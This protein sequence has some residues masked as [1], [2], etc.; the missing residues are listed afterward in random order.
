[1]EG[2][3]HFNSW[4][5][6]RE[7]VQRPSVEQRHKRVRPTSHKPGTHAGVEKEQPESRLSGG[8]NIPETSASTK[9]LRQTVE[10]SEEQQGGQCDWKQE[11]KTRA[12]I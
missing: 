8:Q 4:G 11:L 5:V 10:L 12:Q 6:G 3:A 1:M 9:T 7:I 2:G